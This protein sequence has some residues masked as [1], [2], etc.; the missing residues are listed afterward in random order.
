MATAGPRRVRLDVG[1]LLAWWVLGQALLWRVTRSARPAP[2][3]SATDSSR[4]SGPAGEPVRLLVSD[5]IAL[6]FTFTWARPVILLPVDLCA[7][8]ATTR[9]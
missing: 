3:P 4:I 6:P 7:N 2:G 8:A 1:R 9:P 5:R